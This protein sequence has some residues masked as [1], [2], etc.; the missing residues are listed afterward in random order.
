MC[1]I[2]RRV[3]SGFH[4]WAAASRLVSRPRQGRVFGESTLPLRQQRRHGVVAAWVAGAIVVVFIALWRSGAFQGPHVRA[5]DRIAIV[6]I[7][8]HSSAGATKM[9]LAQGTISVRLNADGTACFLLGDGP[10]IW[11]H[12]WSGAVDRVSGEV[13]LLNSRSRRFAKVGTNVTG[14]GGTL[15]D[16]QPAQFCSG[17]AAFAIS[18]PEVTDPAVPAAG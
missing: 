9:A 12:G 5:S 10:V 13:W 3:R 6:R 1:A 16:G 15:P 17:T 2:I 4:S 18:H 14:A 11:P 8:T 7:A